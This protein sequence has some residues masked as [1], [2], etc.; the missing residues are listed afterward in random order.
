ML[1]GIQ[2]TVRSNEKKKKTVTLLCVL[3]KGNA[4]NCMLSRLINCLQ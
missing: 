3:L 4:T 2:F 1:A